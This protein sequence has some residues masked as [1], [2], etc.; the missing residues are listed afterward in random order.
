MCQSASEIDEVVKNAP[1]VAACAKHT[2]TK[3]SAA[4][5]RQSCI[6]HDVW[7][8]R[9]VFTGSA[10]EAWSK[11]HRPTVAGHNEPSEVIEF[12]RRNCFT[13]RLMKIL[14]STRILF[15]YL[16]SITPA[17]APVVR[18]G[19]RSFTEAAELSALH[20]GHSC[21]KRRKP[22]SINYTSAPSPCCR[23]GLSLVSRSWIEPRLVTHAVCLLY[24]QTAAGGP[25]ASRV[26]AFS[27]E[28][29]PC[30]DVCPTQLL[31]DSFADAV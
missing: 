22:L 27:G 9:L 17:F 10:N 12:S 4:A 13:N 6:D 1:A 5:W 18:R 25:N 15:L 16:A 30:L 28:A 2:A 26:V 21:C 3:V 24:A 23:R 11:S 7:R 14:S 8:S 19:H 20:A 31:E 29:L